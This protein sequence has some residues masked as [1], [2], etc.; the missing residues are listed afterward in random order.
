MGNNCFTDTPK[1]EAFFKDTQISSENSEVRS[2]DSELSG[3]GI[4][5]NS[6]VPTN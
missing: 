3:V 5:Q 2:I 1:G 6:V 4:I